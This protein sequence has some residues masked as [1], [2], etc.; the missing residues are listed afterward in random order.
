MSSQPSSQSTETIFDLL[1]TDLC[2]ARAEETAAIADAQALRNSTP[3]HLNTQS[4]NAF[5][6]AGD[7][8]MVAN[9]RKTD[10]V[11]ALGALFKEPPDMQI[12]L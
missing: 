9:L 10:A 7:R 12:A 2:D 8:M 1:I 4:M 6:K 11:E 5:C 3:G